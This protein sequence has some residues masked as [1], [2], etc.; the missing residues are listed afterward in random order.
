MKKALAI[1]LAVA[2]LCIMAVGTTLT[3]FTDT[4]FDKNVM[5]VGKVE[6]EQIEVFSANS[7]LRPYIGEV[8]DTGDFDTAK[9]AVTKTVTVQY[10][11][12][13]EE[14]YIRTLFAF[15]AFNGDPI[16]NSK[17]HANFTSA[18]NVACV[19]SVVVDGV[20]Y[21]VYSFTYNSPV[22][23]N[24]I[25]EASLKQIALDCSVG[26]EFYEA[27]GAEYNI[28]V[29]SQAVQSTGFANAAD[30]FAAAFPYG[31]NN[32]NVANWFN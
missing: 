17:I 26:N 23:G 19:G 28:L 30:A 15:E 2:L 3:Y 27:V 1:I 22:T 14:A 24:A 29:L 21:I 5:T 10:N 32:A 20:T 16:A 18:G 4:D 11:T 31:E 9:N 7:A 8:P 6:I 25:T 13:T 12:E